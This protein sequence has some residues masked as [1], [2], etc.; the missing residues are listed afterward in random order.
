MKKITISLLAL[1]GIV[2]L[3]SC[4]VKTPTAEVKVEETQP[5]AVE[6]NGLNLDYMDTSVRPQDDFFS[7]HIRGGR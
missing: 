2:M 1:Y 6:E 7:F 4:A 3:N 5:K